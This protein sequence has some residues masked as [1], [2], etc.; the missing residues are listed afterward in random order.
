MLG[1]TICHKGAMM[2]GRFRVQRTRE[3]LLDFSFRK[4]E[5]R[6]A[7][8]FPDLKNLQRASFVNVRLP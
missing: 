3:G 1:S 6:Y 5:L 8:P 7:N 2:V 4:P